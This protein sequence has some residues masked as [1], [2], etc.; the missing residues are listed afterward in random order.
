[1]G[2]EQAWK[3]FCTEKKNLDFPSISAQELSVDSKVAKYN[4]DDENYG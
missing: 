2:R 4:F 3:H 1:M